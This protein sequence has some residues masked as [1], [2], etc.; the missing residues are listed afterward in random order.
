[1]Q[2][3]DWGLIG[4]IVI[5]EGFKEGKAACCGMGP[6]RGVFSC[7]GKRVVKEYELCENPS[8]YLFWD[9]YHLTESAYK[10]FA[11]QMWS[12][13]GSSNTVRPYA[14]RDLFQVP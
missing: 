13:T 8:D 4:V 2:Y 10:Q 1:M 11:A 12:H 5:D 14:M 6:F 3:F 7:G 9:S